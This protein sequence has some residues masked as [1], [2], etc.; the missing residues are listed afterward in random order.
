MQKLFTSMVMAV[1][2]LITA[3]VSAQT[4]EQ[5]VEYSESYYYSEGGTKP[6]SPFST[7]LRYYD[8][9]GNMAMSIVGGT[10]MNIYTYNADGTVATSI[11]YSLGYAS[12]LWAYSSKTSYEYDSEGNL[13]RSNSL[14][15]NDEVTGY[16]SYEGYQNG[17]YSDMKNVNAAGDVTYW[18]HMEHTFE[19][20]DGV[21]TETISYN[22]N[23]E[24]EDQTISGKTEY[25]YSNGLLSNAI[26]YS[27]DGSEYIE[28]GGTVY[29][30]ENGNL[31]SEVITSIYSGSPSYTE[32]Y[33]YYNDYSASYKPTNFT[34]SDG[35]E[36]NTLT[37]S[38]TAATSGNVTGYRIFVDQ[39]LTEV[40][41]GTS[42]TTGP[43]ANGEHVFAVLP[44]VNNSTSNVSDIKFYSVYDDG[45][46]PATNLRAT[47]IGQ[48]DEDNMTYDIELAWDAPST[49]SEL[50]GYTLY[51]YSDWN[52]ITID[53]N[54]TSTS[55]TI[56]S[57][58]TEAYDWETGDSNPANVMF[59]IV[60][61]YTTGVADA[62]NTVLVSFQEGEVATAVD[63]VDYV[64]VAVY[65]NPATDY[66]NFSE[67]VSVK[68]YSL[69]G[70]IALMRTDFVNGV[71]IAD[72]AA[73]I[74]IVETT[75]ISG[76][77]SQTKL[78][79]K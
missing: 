73:G 37:L 23:L 79:V 62:S 54:V 45:V 67:E 3:N 72:L 78:M 16:T 58:L 21:L 60:A 2:L 56:N 65:P 9:N 27:Y 24:T 30:Y 69:T 77:K 6:E 11:S 64:E 42:Y 36:Q 76:S 5:K 57:S 25:L 61:N 17:E 39:L 66:I 53:A 38:W 52:S 35:T 63:D 68:I 46:V 20:G 51:Y 41:E 75:T 13:T 71:S 50:T 10:A 44:I 40:V 26:N 55:M 31:E 19:N 15:E 12:N 1:V 47:T 29:T 43:L 32:L 8:E 22:V 34:V 70:S 49:T 18:R 48:L 74:Y 28:A 14:D 7:T 4:V 59:Y 33:Y